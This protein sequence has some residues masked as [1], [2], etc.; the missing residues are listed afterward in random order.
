MDNYTSQQW[1]IFG[2]VVQKD[3]GYMSVAEDLAIDVQVVKDTIQMW[4]KE[5]PELFPVESENDN[6]KR[7]VN[8]CRR[9]KENLAIVSYDARKSATDDAHKSATDDVDDEIRHKY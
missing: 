1:L 9:V 3:R 2:E 5:Q 6:M 4:R 8:H 7:H